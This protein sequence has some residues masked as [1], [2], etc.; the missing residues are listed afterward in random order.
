MIKN[1]EEMHK[2]LCEVSFYSGKKKVTHNWNI[3]MIKIDSMQ[4]LDCCV[5]VAKH[6][7]IFMVD[8]FSEQATV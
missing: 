6:L 3:I 2:I 5:G 4:C 1:K 8:D 7:M